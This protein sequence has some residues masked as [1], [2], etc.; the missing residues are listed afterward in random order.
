MTIMHPDF[1]QPESPE[2]PLPPGAVRWQQQ[3]AKEAVNADMHAEARERYGNRLPMVIPFWYTMDDIVDRVH[4][5]NRVPQFIGT[6]GQR[7]SATRKRDNGV[8]EQ[9]GVAA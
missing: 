5:Y 7:I 3:Q 8:A 1:T 4:G 6:V 9:T 2:P